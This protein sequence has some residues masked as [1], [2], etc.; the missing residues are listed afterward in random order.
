[1]ENQLEQHKEVNG[2]TSSKVQELISE[3]SVLKEKVK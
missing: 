1:M 3:N 2:S